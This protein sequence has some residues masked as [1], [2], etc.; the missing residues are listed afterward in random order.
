MTEA[1][2]TL[3]SSDASGAIAAWHGNGVS[4]E[5][6]AFARAAVAAADPR[7]PA[8]ARALLWSC[9]RLAA[10]GAG[11]GLE[12]VAEV[13]LHPSVIERFVTVGM[14]RASD[15]AR[16]TARTNLRFVAR[17]AAPQLAHPPPAPPLAR[18]RAKAPYGPAEVAAYFALAGAQPTLARRARLQGLLC[19]GLGAGLERAELRHITGRHVIA[20][21]GGV[22]VVVEG[23]RARAVP[24]LVR[25]QPRLVAS[26]AFAG[27][28]FICG[29]SSPTRKNLT[30]SLVGRIA[31][32]A[33]LEPLDVGRLRATWLAEH[34]ERLGLVALLDAAG[35]VCSQRLGDLARH[36][37]RL[38][39][40]AVV[41]TLGAR[42]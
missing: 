30:A 24:V 7:G 26:A 28:G 10:W 12:L 29:G 6:M 36:L 9:S 31:G 18:S 19:L 2:P 22:V 32:G 21:S 37:A 39:E 38:D 23:P 8:R 16:R 41:E 15:S 5:A 4:F 27:E 14:P 33:D 40:A 34:L 35:V 13:L 17:R 11:V 42:R 20:R 3:T 25:Y 1:A